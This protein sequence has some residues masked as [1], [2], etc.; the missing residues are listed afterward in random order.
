LAGPSKR[1]TKKRCNCFLLQK[2]RHEKR[3]GSRPGKKK[4]QSPRDPTNC[5]FD[6][7]RQT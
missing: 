2:K 3:C 4:Q 7:H 5:R 6:L 1:G